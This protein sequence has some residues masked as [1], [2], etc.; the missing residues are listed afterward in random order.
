MKYLATTRVHYLNKH[1]CLRLE[2]WL[3]VKLRGSLNNNNNPEELFG[4]AQFSVKKLL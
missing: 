2:M 1:V 4:L 3:Q